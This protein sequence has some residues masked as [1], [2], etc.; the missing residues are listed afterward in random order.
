MIECDYWGGVIT[1]QRQAAAAE[2]AAAGT[3][4]IGGLSDEHRQWLI[5]N[6]VIAS[7]PLQLP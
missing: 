7:D 4:R 1:G 3:L 5:G 6:L 2:L